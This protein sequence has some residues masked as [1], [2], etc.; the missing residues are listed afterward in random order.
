MPIRPVIVVQWSVSPAHVPIDSG[1]S[2]AGLRKAMHRACRFWEPVIEGMVEFRECNPRSV[3]KFNHV[4]VRVGP[5]DRSDDEDRVAQNVEWTPRPSLSTITLASDRTWKT[6]WW[7]WFRQYDAWI[8]LAHELG[9]VLDIP[10]IQTHDG[11]RGLRD[12]ARPEIGMLP[13]NADVEWV[14]GKAIPMLN[15][16]MTEREWRTYRWYFINHGNKLYKEDLAKA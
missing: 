8:V 2:V 1:V 11:K 6:D 12:I 10:H 7:Q 4:A 5:V 9:H 16:R 15:T 3:P 14:M 13:R